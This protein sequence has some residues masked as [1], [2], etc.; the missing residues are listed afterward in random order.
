VPSAATWN[1][2][3]GQILSQIVIAEIAPLSLL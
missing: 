1:S 2:R 3:K